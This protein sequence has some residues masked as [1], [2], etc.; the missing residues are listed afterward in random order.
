MLDCL[1]FQVQLALEETE[2]VLEL[3]DFQVK[4]DK[5]ENLLLVPEVEIVFLES[6]EDQDKREKEVI[7]DQEEPLVMLLKELLDNLVHQDSK[8]KKVWMDLQVF[9]ENKDYL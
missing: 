9:Q 7:K 8:D 1:V 6:M 3:L 2:A 5:K 4:K